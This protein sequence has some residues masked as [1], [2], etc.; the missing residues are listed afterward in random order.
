LIILS[1]LKWLF[2][3]WQTRVKMH[4]TAGRWISLHSP[5]R[6]KYTRITPSGKIT[7]ENVEDFLPIGKAKQEGFYTRKTGRFSFP[8]RIPIQVITPIEASL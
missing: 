5:M 2:D 3:K 8:S 7:K 1:F 4:F 6:L